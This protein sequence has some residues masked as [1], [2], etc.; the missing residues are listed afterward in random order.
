[1]KIENRNQ[2]NIRIAEISGR[3]D[4]STTAYFEEELNKILTD[5]R[6]KVLLNMKQVD[7]ISSSGL[8][9]FITALKKVRGANGELKIC[10]MSPN[11]QKIFEISGFV[12]LFDISSSE[13]EALQKFQT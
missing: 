11:I 7:Y 5:N 9:V 4:P 8:R 2:N 12:Q 6:P 3:I 13:E 10:S 1:M